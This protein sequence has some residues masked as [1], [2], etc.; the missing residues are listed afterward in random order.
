MSQTQ[1]TNIQDQKTLQSDGKKVS[2]WK[3]FLLMGFIVLPI[4]TLLLICAYGF[5]VWFGQMLFWG[6]PGP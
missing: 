6:P 2:E 5:A 3:R 1:S 4:F